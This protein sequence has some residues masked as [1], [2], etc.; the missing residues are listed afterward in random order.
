MIMN[1]A[2]IDFKKRKNN[3]ITIKLFEL[4]SIKKISIN[5]N[6]SKDRLKLKHILKFESFRLR[7]R[8][9]TRYKELLYNSKH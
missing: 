1:Y 9:Q 5:L 7:K 2:N 6:N 3:F 4:N 8:D